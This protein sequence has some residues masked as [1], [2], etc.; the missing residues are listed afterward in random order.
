M[1]KV[2]PQ[3]IFLSL[4]NTKKSGI[5][6]NPIS[7]AHFLDK[8]SAQGVVRI[9]NSFATHWWIGNTQVASQLSQLNFW[10]RYEHKVTANT[11]IYFFAKIALEKTWNVSNNMLV[12]G[13]GL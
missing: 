4:E 13:G 10:L 5:W 9:H 11:N 3:S 6:K 2:L 1:C 8:F 7:Q 12:P